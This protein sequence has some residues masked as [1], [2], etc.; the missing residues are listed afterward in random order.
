VGILTMAFLYMIKGDEYSRAIVIIFLMAMYVIL[1]L[2][3]SLLSKVNIFMVKKGIGSKN[4]LMGSD[5]SA[6]RFSEQLK[7]T[8]GD[9]YQI[10]GFVKNK[11][12]TDSSDV[13]PHII[14][15]CND[16]NTIIR[17]KNIHQVFIVSD[18]MNLDKYTSV[19][20]ACERY[21]INLKMVSPH[22]K[23]LM[24]KRKIKDVTGVPLVTESTRSRYLYY[25]KTMKRILDILC[26]MAGG[27]IIVPAG[28]LIALLIKLTSK[29]PVFFKQKRSLYLGGPEFWFLKFRS[30]CIDADKLKG[31]LLTENES[32]GALFK[33][34]KDP[35]I[36]PVGRII[37]KF[38]LDEFPQFINV[39]KGEMSI[40]GPRPL[41]V[42][43]YKMLKNTDSI[44][45][46]WYKKRGNALPGITGLWQISGR[47]ELS[48]EE[49]CLLDLYYIEN[50]SVFF[51]L[52]I[53]FETV[54][55]ML[56]GRGY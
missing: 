51:D 6:Y 25:Q 27:I 31:D 50:Q 11:Y 37:R 21:G 23:N 55:V 5:E 29:G 45:C 28:I 42:K 40:V 54:Y 36:T 26:L 32:N 52:E 3:H 2:N 35:R 4:T 46:E 9:F 8:Y 48:F 44:C 18:S 49:M 30:M 12:V 53:M 20:K 15:T 14:G 1:E 10:K 41:P 7:D 24:K 33:I 43:D 17:E 19:R 38:S 16:I 34:K 47:N 39:L 22:I 56:F 13:V